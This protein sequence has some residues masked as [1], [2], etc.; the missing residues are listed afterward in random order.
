MN[1]AMDKNILPNILENFF[2]QSKHKLWPITSF[3]VAID[4]DSCFI[5]SGGQ[6]QMLDV[7]GIGMFLAEWHLACD[8]KIIK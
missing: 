1:E 7:L 8:L 4:K 6:G 5:E 3:Q 2:V